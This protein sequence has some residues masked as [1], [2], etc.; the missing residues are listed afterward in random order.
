M[1]PRP[2][3]TLASGEPVEA[4]TLRNES[5]ATA[6]ILNYGATVTSL[7]MP[8]RRGRLADVVLGFKDLAGYLE[9]DAYVGAI[10]GRVAGRLRGGELLLGGGRR[11]LE[12]N[13]GPHHLHGGKRG[14][15]KRVWRAQ[16]GRGKEGASSLRL[17][18]TSPD[19]EEGY[20][21]RVD[22][23]VTYTLTAANE[24]VVEAEATSDTETPLSLAQH[25]YFNLAG[26]DSG[27]VEGHEVQIFAEE[28]VPADDT[29]APSGSS[30][31]VAG[32]GADF[33]RAR[34]LGDA[35]PELFRSHGD[36]YVLRAGQEQEPGNPILAARVVDGAS[37]RVLEVLTDEACL[38]FYTGV[39]LGGTPSGKSGALYG[40]HAGFCMECQGYP[41]AS[42][43]GRFGDILVR[44]GRTWRRCTLYAFS[45]C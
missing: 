5:G 8:D 43:M 45:T 35:L 23:S 42:G 28:Y 15:D 1:T 18:Y 16:P 25:S 6:E 41:S 14:L 20:P 27:S 4:Y 38:Q 40:R 30:R 37:G 22:I 34:R 32:S 29:L 19:G 10:V 12:R 33:R 24:L 26:E 7:R 3:G 17:S 9:G 31:S 13:D 44:P 2:Y 21:G 39:A 11:M 36:L